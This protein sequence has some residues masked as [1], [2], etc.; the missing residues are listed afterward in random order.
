MTITLYFV[1]SLTVP[2]FTAQVTN[3]QNTNHPQPIIPVI[4]RP[5]GNSHSLQEKMGLGD[6]PEKYDVIRV[7]CWS[8]FLP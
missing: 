8:P 4:P 3:L 1:D 5:K 2:I 6:D 7:C